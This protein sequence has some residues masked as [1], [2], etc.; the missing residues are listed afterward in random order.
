MHGWHDLFSALD[1]GVGAYHAIYLKKLIFSVHL[2]SLR[3][4]CNTRKKPREREEDK[5][6]DQ[7]TE[8]IEPPS[9]VQS[10][11]ATGWLPLANEHRKGGC[12]DLRCAANVKYML[13]FKDVLYRKQAKY[14]ISGFLE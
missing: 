13:D 8:A 3:T 2:V 10:S 12:S 11:P 1:S 5:R 9:P 14:R 6:A 7:K 4:R